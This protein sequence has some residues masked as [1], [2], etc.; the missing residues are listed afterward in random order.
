MNRLFNLIVCMAFLYGS[1]C[2]GSGDFPEIADAGGVISYQGKPLASASVIFTPETGPIAV[3][4]TDDDGK[5]HLLTQGKTGAKLGK[6]T[7]IVQA[8]GP[9]SGTKVVTNDPSTG[10]DLP[11]QMVSRIPE[12]Y[13]K[14]NQSGLTADVKANGENSFRFELQ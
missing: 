2:A 8:V 9:K 13:G 3:G 12:K 4:M 14:T 6:H 10:R 7:V 5:F 11:V 1:G